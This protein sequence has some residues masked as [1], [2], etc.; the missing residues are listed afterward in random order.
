MSQTILT[1]ISE[2]TPCGSDFKYEDAYLALE[3]EIDKSTSMSEGVA[4]D[5]SKVLDDAESLLGQDTKDTKIMCWWTYAMFK[6]GSWNALSTALP[7]F[8]DFLLSFGEALFPK[9]KKVKLSSILWLEELFNEEMLDERGAFTASVDAEN[10]L[11]YFK[12]LEKNFGISVG[13]E[14]SLFKKLQSA[15]ERLVKEQEVKE[16]APKSSAAQSVQTG[17]V[18]LSEI[19]SDADATSILRSLKKNAG[20]LQEYFRTQD[21]SDIRAIRLVRLQSWLDIDSLPMHEESKTPL[22]PPSQESIDKIEELMAEEEY[23]AALES[24]ES[25]IALSPFWLEGHLMA[26]NILSEMG[27]LQAAKEVQNALV[28]FI[29]ADEAILNLQFRDTTPFAS[30]KLKTW[31]A[32]SMGAAISTGAEGSSTEESKEQII[33][34]AYALAKKKNIK[35]AMGLLQGH[36]GLSVTKE[37]KFH[38][39]LAKAELATQFGKNDVALALLEDLKED[40]DRYNL[41]EWN[42]ELAGRVFSLYLGLNRTQVKVEDMH[43]AYSR[44]CKINIEHALEIKL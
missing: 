43:A 39:R 25:L 36:H 7:L 42:P 9:S 38:W 4:T 28:S 41:D 32:E 21:P 19:N 34:K 15:L 3:S 13:E 22:N 35:E 37:D 40:I 10:F 14:L 20:L 11:G 2:T 29:K 24:T 8:N 12:E 33:E 26:F 1:P 27:H 30:I 6:T 44:L 23:A 31:I 16:E 18:E 5:W 17:T